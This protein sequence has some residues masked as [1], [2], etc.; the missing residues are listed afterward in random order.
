MKQ[1]SKVDVSFEEKLKCSHFDEEKILSTEKIRSENVLG[2][3]LKKCSS[4]KIKIL[5]KNPFERHMKQHE[6]HLSTNYASIESIPEM[7]ESQIVELDESSPSLCNQ[8]EL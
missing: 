4:S 8:R 2:T 1:T 5:V 3:G 6:T 7:K